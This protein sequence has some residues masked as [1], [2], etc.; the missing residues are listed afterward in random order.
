MDTNASAYPRLE[1]SATASSRD[2]VDL[3]V[4]L[5]VADA[6][7]AEAW[8]EP[9][10][11]GRPIHLTDLEG[12]LV[13]FAVPYARG[14][15]R[16][17]SPEELFDRVRA[18]RAAVGTDKCGTDIRRTAAV[19]A[20]DV[21][22]FG[23]IY[24]SAS[25]HAPPILGLTESLHA[26][27]LNADL[28]LARM[29]SED[30]AAGPT[31]HRVVFEGPDSEY[32]EVRCGDRINYIH[33]DTLEV[34]TIDAI[35]AARSSRMVEALDHGPT[36]DRAIDAL[37][38]AFAGPEPEAIRGVAF[39]SVAEKKLM[40]HWQLVPVVNWTWWC[41]P[42]AYTMAVGYWDNYVRGKGTFIGYGRLITHWMKHQ[43]FKD[44]NVPSFIDQLID[45]TT[46]SWRKGFTDFSDFIEKTFGYNVVK[47]E[48]AAHAGNDWGWAELTKEIDADRP[49]V[50]STPEPNHAN[51]AIGYRTFSSGVRTVIVYST[52]GHTATDQLREWNYET[53]GGFARLR[54]SGGSGGQHLILHSPFG[55]EKIAN[56]PCKAIWFV[57]GSDIARSRIWL[58]EDSGGSWHSVADNI[59]TKPGWNSFE[60]QP[61]RSSATARVRVEGYTAAGSLVAADGSRE[62]FVIDTVPPAGWTRIHSSVTSVVVGYDSIE[63]TSLLFVTAAADASFYRYDGMPDA[64]TMIGGPGRAF[65][66][67]GVGRVYG[68]SPNGSGIWQ[69]AGQPMTWR[70]IGGVAG[71]IHAGGNVL[72]M[73]DAT[74]GDLYRY[75]GL[76][77]RW[78]RIGGPGKMFA[79]DDTGRIYGI[80]VTGGAIFRYDGTPM[81]WT[82]IGEG[83]Q[84]IQ[85]GG[86]T[87]CSVSE[88]GNLLRLEAASQTW[89]KI[90]GPGKMFAITGND[91]VYGLSSDAQAVLRHDEASGSWQRIGNAAMSIHAGAGNV[92][93]AIDAAGMLR[94][95]KG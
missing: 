83:S 40:D 6:H 44:N 3:Q 71:T 29:R 89:K 49:V 55:N 2:P 35:A 64:W 93:C 86:R 80:S 57:W 39:R 66:A 32:F 27:Y 58:S 42:T 73:T 4:A 45:P 47:E 76:P 15:E 1:V 41:V 68:V 77:M 8:G 37:P 26:Y 54:F 19:S 23:T 16:F 65:V 7:A 72:C 14:W 67:D 69:F 28:A 48:T 88:G 91:I 95:Y 79:I 38:E 61:S 36:W 70:Q 34:R 84:A 22:S 52:W 94:V 33:V 5:R 31:L 12:D 9:L 74:T 63:A 43:K 60:W 90:G 25:R 18:L 11:R 51:C 10:K 82:R 21:G 75:D 56:G 20:Q 30:I 78:T 46:G 53:A 92:L 87:L 85:A 24:V 59:A 50:W 13:A 17:P 81:R 62:N